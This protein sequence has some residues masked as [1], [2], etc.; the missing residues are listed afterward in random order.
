MFAL[1]FALVVT[2]SGIVQAQIPAPNTTYNATGILIPGAHTVSDQA[3]LIA[4]RATVTLSGTAAFSSARSYQCTTDDGFG[5][6]WL[7]VVRVNG[8]SF[9]IISNNA[10]STNVVHFQCV[11]N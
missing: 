3:V 6:E 9:S 10:T 7:I 8:A 1:A 5:N 2:V 4:G 11:G